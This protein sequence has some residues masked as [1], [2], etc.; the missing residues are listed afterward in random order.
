MFCIL[1]IIVRVSKSI[2]KKHMYIVYLQANGPPQ[3]D[4]SVHGQV[5]G[6]KIN[7][8]SNIYR[9]LHKHCKCIVCSW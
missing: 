1:L 8:L 4:H 3:M 6:D 7:N 5:V 2:K 9:E